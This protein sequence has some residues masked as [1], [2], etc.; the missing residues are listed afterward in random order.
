MPSPTAQGYLAHRKKKRNE[1]EKLTL[2]SMQH[3][4]RNPCRDH[5]AFEE[6]QGYLAVFEE[7]QSYVCSIFRGTGLPRSFEEV[8]EHLKRHR[9]TCSI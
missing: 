8:K 6:V 7:V 4:K 9:A 5:A 1:I 3:L 2:A